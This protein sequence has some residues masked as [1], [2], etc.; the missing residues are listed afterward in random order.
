MQQNKEAC[1]RI[2]TH[3][4][5]KLNGSP[6]SVWSEKYKGNSKQG[7]TEVCTK[8]L[9]TISPNSKWS[10]E[11][12][13]IKFIVIYY[14]SFCIRNETLSLV[15]NS[16]QGLFDRMDKVH[17]KTWWQDGQIRTLTMKK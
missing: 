13:L 8:Q 14:T 4:N 1:G 11:L 3:D 15:K 10:K 12:V 5:K 16:V 7:V 17:M 9:R 6:K 2:K